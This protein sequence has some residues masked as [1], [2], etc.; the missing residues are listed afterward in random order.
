MPANKKNIRI[1]LI[2]PPGS[3]KGTQSLK[4]INRYTAAHVSSGDVL[5]GEVARGTDFGKKVKSF[6]DKGEIGPA[7][8]ITE[9][10]LSH[11]DSNC[12][13][14]FVL[15]GFPRTLYQAEELQKRQQLNAALYLS[16]PEAEIVARITGRRTC[17]GC[18]RIFHVIYDPPAQPELCDDCQGRLMQREDDNRETVIT[19]MRVFNEQTKPVLDF[20]REAGLLRTVD[21]STSPDNVFRKI[22]AILSS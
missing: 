18:N 13:N 12:K 16:V 2:G 4:L 8:L 21:G 17:T 15:D 11:V 7:E 3:G 22:E 14:G 1:T 9:V 20:Y 19:R 6:M 10:I 5:R